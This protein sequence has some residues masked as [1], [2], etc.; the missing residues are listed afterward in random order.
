[1]VGFGGSDMYPIFESGEDNEDITLSVAA[2]DVRGSLDTEVDSLSSAGSLVPGAFLACY[3]C[4]VCSV[5]TVSPDSS[6]SSSALSSIRP[7]TSS[8][9]SHP[10]LPGSLS[11]NSVYNRFSPLSPVSCWRGMYTANG[12]IYNVVAKLF[13]DTHLEYLE[14]EVNMMR[15]LAPLDCVPHLLG[16]L[17]PAKQSYWSLML[18]EWVGPSLDSGGKVTWAALNLDHSERYVHFVHLC[19]GVKFVAVFKSI[20]S[21]GASMR[22]A[23]RT[24]ISSPGTFVAF[25]LDHTS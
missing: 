11:L 15:Q 13:D 25:L 23:W 8:A 19:I 22:Q 5:F 3:Y 9:T 6:R 12:Q 21:S 7:R 4:F 17:R 2:L 14:R 24:G 10:V 16:T 18:M 1:M 20:P